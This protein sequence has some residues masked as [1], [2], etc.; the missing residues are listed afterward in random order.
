MYGCRGEDRW[1]ALS[2]WDDAEWRRFRD[3]LGDPEWARAAALATAEGRRAR[4]GEL[5][6]R[7]G[8]WTRERSRQDVVDALRAKGLRAAAV[9]SIGELFEDAQLA[10]RRMWRRV[11]HPVFG[12]ITT[13]APP[14]VLSG[15]PTRHEHAGP[16]LGADNDY[17]YG[18]V[19]GLGADERAALAREGVLD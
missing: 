17:V 4:E 9:E 5:D 15:T 12:E 3:A 7:I 10:H 11:P 18:E 8:E 19:L 6:R 13:M 1:V 2:V 14:Y 16:T